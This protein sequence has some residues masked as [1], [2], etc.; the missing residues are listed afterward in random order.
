MDPQ[1][2]EVVRQK[3]QAFLDHAATESGPSDDGRQRFDDF[4]KAAN[5]LADSY[6]ASVPTH[7]V[8]PTEP[9][10]TSHARDNWF[11]EIFDGLNQDIWDR[12]PGDRL[13]FYQKFTMAGQTLTVVL[14]IGLFVWGVIFMAMNTDEWKPGRTQ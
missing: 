12:Q 14:I 13:T 6:E 1:V 10:P 9:Q 3:L 11:V 2:G 7:P 8:A 5:D 4:A